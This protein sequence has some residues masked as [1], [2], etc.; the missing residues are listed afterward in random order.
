MGEKGAFTDP[1]TW[2]EHFQGLRE[3]VAETIKSEPGSPVAVQ[4]LGLVRE[5]VRIF[6]DL[7]ETEDTRQDFLA[8]SFGEFFSFILRR[9]VPWEWETM[10]AK[11]I[12]ET[13]PERGTEEDD[14]VVLEW[15]GVRPANA[16]E[17]AAFSA[18]SK[19]LAWFITTGLRGPVL[20]HRLQALS[21]FPEGPPPTTPG[22]KVSWGFQDLDIAEN[23]AKGLGLPRADLVAA[24]THGPILPWGVTLGGGPL[25][26][27]KAFPFDDDLTHLL[28]MDAGAWSDLRFH[29]EIRGRA[30]ESFFS[31]TCRGLEV[32]RDQK[33]AC[34]I[35][36]ITPAWGVR[37]W[38]EAVDLE[39]MTVRDAHREEALA[40]RTA[41]LEWTREDWTTWADSVSSSLTEAMERL[42]GMG[43]KLQAKM[44]VS[45]TS[46]ASLT[47][48]GEAVGMVGEPEAVVIE[49]PAAELVLTG[50]TPAVVVSPLGVEEV[51]PTLATYVAGEGFLSV[52]G[53]Q[54]LKFLHKPAPDPAKV[55]TLEEEWEARLKEGVAIQEATGE[56]PDWIEENRR[57]GAGNPWKLKESE[58]QRIREELG[59]SPHG[60][61]EFAGGSEPR[62]VRIY[63]D[64]KGKRWEFYL[65][66]QWR[67]LNERRRQ[68]VAKVLEEE[69][70]RLV[71]TGKTL[72]A[73]SA[74]A[75]FPPLDE[76]GR[77]QRS[78][79]RVQAKREALT[80][81][82]RAIKVLAFLRK[83]A[84]AQRQ[85]TVE[86]DADTFK[87]W[88]WGTEEAPDNWLSTVRE[89]LGMLLDISAT[90]VGVTQGAGASLVQWEYRAKDAPERGQDA[91][92]SA[93]G[94]NIVF[95]VTLNPILLGG[96]LLLESTPRTLAHGRETSTFDTS[97]KNR[98]K[99]EKE[100]E[101]TGDRLAY[102]PELHLD[103]F[104]EVLGEPPEVQK[105]G[106]TLAD[107]ITAAGSAI[108]RKWTSK[109]K[110]GKNP[111]GSMERHYTRRFCDL[112]PE[113]T[114]FHGAL[115]NF[116][117]SPEGGWRMA[118]RHN[119]LRRTNYSLLEFM[120]IEVPTGGAGD[121]RREAFLRGLQA[122]R[123][124]VLDLGEGLLAV[125]L[126]D[127][128]HDLGAGMTEAQ[129][130]HLLQNGKV[131]PFFSP[132]WIAKVRAAYEAKAALVLPRDAEE[133]R[134]RRWKKPQ[135]DA[136]GFPLHVQLR[137]AMEGRGLTQLQAAGEIGVSQKT[138]SV[139]L[140]GE[141]P[142]SPE[143]AA[144]VRE[145]I[146][147]GGK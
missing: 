40:M 67:F 74:G 20:F 129:A 57:R 116:G 19:G 27:P 94:S 36:D 59:R 109:P 93:R 134:D 28:K 143:S 16:V 121:R 70:E 144:K 98:R 8:P 147:R 103:H 113:G 11:L 85:G 5:L 45:G 23:I 42:G 6:P 80:S 31:V 60:V 61:A 102:S 81:W 4:L 120:D 119:D 39:T 142:L 22:V 82:G 55:K 53:G 90:I 68:A 145:W 15:Q 89:T 92:K 130:I 51:E 115:G 30:W 117:Q 104:L 76:I 13:T 69:E 83:Q 12:R 29:G 88:I 63:E 54:Q 133:A 71:Q 126:G 46:T 52:R 50:L 32:D 123:R 38:E 122:L 87:L 41:A 91:A 84:S 65:G 107:H 35:V 140:K 141:K 26:A 7:M 96:L 47:I 18:L 100:I 77:N 44:V 10:T 111:D 127:T 78:L 118:G 110:G 58:K 37:E 56:T 24:M 72:E 137:S 128:W 101:K 86:V 17:T 112:I 124:V 131:F 34:F 95:F 2:E 3:A 14:S 25:S 43:A 108:S 9:P 105:L 114:V 64:Q 132:G 136:E 106:Q 97:E 75:L 139:W 1:V 79:E 135:P 33:T 48:G 138:V 73:Q 62:W 49:P 99:K 21:P 66:G 146:G 125:R